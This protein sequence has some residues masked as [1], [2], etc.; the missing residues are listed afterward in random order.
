MS[1]DHQNRADL[2]AT[3]KRIKSKRAGLNTERATLAASTWTARKSYTVTF[4]DGT[5]GVDYG[6]RSP[7]YRRMWTR[8]MHAAG[9]VVTDDMTVAEAAEVKARIAEVSEAIRRD[10]RKLADA[11]LDRDTLLRHGFYW[12][13]ALDD[14]Q[15]LLST[16]VKP[17]AA[18][19]PVPVATVLSNLNSTIIA[20]TKRASDIRQQDVMTRKGQAERLVA[21]AN[22]LAKLLK[23]TA[24]E[25]KLA[26]ALVSA[27][28][29]ASAAATAAKEA[30][31]AAKAARQATK[32]A[33]TKP[34]KEEATTTK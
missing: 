1:I 12:T 34:A 30:A 22:A 14:S 8:L 25:A 15:T 13:S 9:F 20:V 11:E 19:P 23:P 32:P 29:E 17:K 31:R 7:E 16:D 26:E 6:G 21:L 27:E 28:A 10:L 5:T 24:A 33:A 18:K 3:L 4:K 2:L